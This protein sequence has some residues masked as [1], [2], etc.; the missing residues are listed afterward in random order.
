MRERFCPASF[1]LIQHEKFIS[2]KQEEDEKIDDYISRFN[3]MAQILELQE[4]QLIAQFISNLKSSIKEDVMIHNPQTLAAAYERA[5]VKAA[6]MGH[7]QNSLEMQMKKLIEMQKE[8]MKTAEK[9]KEEVQSIA[10]IDQR[11]MRDIADVRQEMSTQ[12]NRPNDSL[13]WYDRYQTDGIGDRFKRQENTQAYNKKREV[14][15]YERNG[16]RYEQPA[17]RSNKPGGNRTYSSPERRSDQETNS[18]N[19]E[20]A[21]EN[22]ALKNRMRQMEQ[23]NR[24]P[25]NAQY[26]RP[27]V[28]CCN[29]SRMGHMARECIAPAKRTTWWR[30]V[31]KRNNSWTPE[32]S[33]TRRTERQN[34]INSLEIKEDSEDEESITKIP[35]DDDMYIKIEIKGQQTKALI[36]SGSTCNGINPKTFEEIRR[37]DKSISLLPPKNATAR[38]VNGSAVDIKGITYLPVKIGATCWTMKLLVMDIG[39]SVL[40]GRRFLKEHNAILD[41]GNNEISIGPEIICLLKVDSQIPEKLTEERDNYQ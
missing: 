14:Q 27:N 24:Q 7:N 19:V 37:R 12:R 20:L 8:Q 35:C 3:K 30:D 6:A 39:P 2:S 4:G 29:C 38:G 10:M 34:T 18:N 36:D 41:T 21:K 25:T 15:A 5:R 11:I 17:Y 13:D 22:A 26:E 32:E 31:E 1:K 40:L 28:K 16:Q 23:Q 9:Q 33:A